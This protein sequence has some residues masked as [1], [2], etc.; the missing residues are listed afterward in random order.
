MPPDCTVVAVVRDNH[1]IA[2]MP[3]TPLHTDDEVL[4]LASTEAEKDLKTAL[5]GD[6]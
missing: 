4:A 3:D 6:I 1:V 5:T 2:P